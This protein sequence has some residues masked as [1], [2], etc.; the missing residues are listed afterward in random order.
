VLTCLGSATFA[1]ALSR[2]PVLGSFKSVIVSGKV[3][4]RLTGKSLRDA[5]FCKAFMA[6]PPANY[7]GEGRLFGRNGHYLKLNDRYGEWPGHY[8]F[9]RDFVF[10]SLA[11]HS[12]KDKLVFFRSKDGAVVFGRYDYPSRNWAPTERVGENGCPDE[13][14]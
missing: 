4:T 14:E 12:K 13:Q 6:P 10:V 11:E 5:V 2:E 8:V 3:Y 9:M 1:A 7:H